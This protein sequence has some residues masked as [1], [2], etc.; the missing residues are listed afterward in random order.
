M[1]TARKKNKKSNRD[2]KIQAQQN[3]KLLNY[4]EIVEKAGDE[5]HVELYY[6]N[7][8]GNI[9]EYV[10]E[11]LQNKT[12]EQKTLKCMLQHYLKMQNEATNM[13][14]KKVYEQVSHLLAIKKEKVKIIL[15]MMTLEPLH[16][17]NL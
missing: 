5:I 8:G 4:A 17:T 2:L 12:L 7:L 9:C 16:K 3:N 11:K 13:R 14:G 15:F 6:K 10:F 1:L